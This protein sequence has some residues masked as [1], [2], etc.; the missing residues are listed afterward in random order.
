MCEPNVNETRDKTTVIR[1]HVW[2]SDR[3]G[4][5][6]RT[7]AA[8]CLIHRPSRFSNNTFS[9]FIENS[10]ADKKKCF[11]CLTKHI[12]RTRAQSSPPET[13]HCY[14]VIVGYLHH[15]LRICHRWVDVSL[16][17][18]FRIDMVTVLLVETSLLLCL[19]VSRFPA[20]SSPVVTLRATS[21]FMC[22]VWIWEQTAIIS[23]YSINWLVCITE[24]ECV[25]C[26]VRAGFLYIILRSAH[27]VFMCVVW[28]W[29]QTAIISLYS[30]NWLVCITETEC[31]YCAYELSL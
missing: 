9:G 24:T 23:V 10:R 4:I 28:I 29:E 15:L 14:C 2:H 1:L 31:V 8:A 11:V 17:S 18:G 13:F 3:I 22:F 19:H 21:V 5:L 6:V 25:Y 30:I 26:A 7:N 16:F 27:N 12:A 20:F